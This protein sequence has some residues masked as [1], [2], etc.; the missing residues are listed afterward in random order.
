L[1]VL[2]LSTDLFSFSV[3]DTLKGA[4]TGMSSATL[5]KVQ[6]DAARRYK[7]AEDIFWAK[8]AAKGSTAGEHL[9]EYSR[10]MALISRAQML[11]YAANAARED[12]KPGLGVAFATLALTTFRQAHTTKAPLDAWRPALELIRQDIERTEHSCRLENDLVAFAK[13]TDPRALEM[14]EPRSLVNPIPFTPT[15][16]I[17]HIS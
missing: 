16:T 3:P 8:G 4:L 15:R 1:L 5:A 7:E 13:I 17:V 12:T 14:P 10:A 9:R 6:A 11:K 2:I